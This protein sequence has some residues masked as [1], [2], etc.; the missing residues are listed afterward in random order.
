MPQFTPIIHV[1]SLNIAQIILGLLVTA[2]FALQPWHRTL[3]NDIWLLTSLF[4]ILYIVYL[5]VRNQ[6]EAIRLPKPLKQILWVC[7]CVPLISI[8][9]YVFTPL[10]NLPLSVL[11]P[12]SRWL[13]I[14]PTIVALRAA[15]IGPFWIFFGLIAYIISTF[16]SAMIE[17][18]FFQNLRIR[19]NGDENAVTYGMFNAT[20]AV[21]I[22]AVFISQYIKQYASQSIQRKLLRITLI[23]FFILGVIAAF[24]SGTR[25]AL[26]ALPFIITILYAIR[27]NPKKALIGCSIMLITFFAFI[28]A[29]QDSTV[30]KR[31]ISTPDR[32]INYFE[33]NDRKSKIT[34]VGQRLEI[35]QESLCIFKKHPLLGTGPRSFKP[36]HQEYGGPD[37]CDATQL[38]SEGFL[39]AHSVYFNTLGTLGLLGIII[40]GLLFFLSAKAAF[41]ALKE[42]NQIIQLGGLILATVLISHIINGITVDLWFKNHVIS[43]N[44]LIWALPFALIFTQARKH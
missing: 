14:I 33:S 3:S 22:L 39:Q 12:D 13:L 21:I 11:E 32:I 8:L 29:N 37:Q 2:Y 5:Y 42:N 23:G 34:S 4:S 24:V 44:L 40:I 1:S 15:R 6:K 30:V 7:A 36:A 20:I 9:S 26:I 43:K 28:Y 38:K 10:D 18:H 31:L 17:T 25:A 41:L 27:Y 35:W 19:A 16:T